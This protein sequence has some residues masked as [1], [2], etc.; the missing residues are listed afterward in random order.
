MADAFK[1]TALAPNQTFPPICPTSKPAAR[2]N[3]EE[4]TS[5]IERCLDIRNV[6]SGT[7]R[8]LFRTAREWELR[9]LS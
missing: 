3:N 9:E 1:K 7:V 5:V 8:H 6:F 2:F 4:Y